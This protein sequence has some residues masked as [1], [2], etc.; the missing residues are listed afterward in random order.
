M[1]QV[2][3]KDYDKEELMRLVGDVSEIAG[4]KKYELLDGKGRGVRAVD[5]WTGT[6]F[7][8]TVV[9]DRGMDI[10]QTSYCGKSLCWRSSI[11]EVH[12]HFF[13]PEEMGWGRSFPGGLLVTCGLTHYGAP[14]EDEGEK[15]GLHGRISHIPA[16]K[17]C[18]DEKWEK[19]D[20]EPS[21][22]GLLRESAIF[23]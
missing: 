11:G 7:S 20:Y 13:E 14:C 4:M 19:D 8:F 21:L 16:E 9:L 17:V 12:P 15:L 10:S 1:A 18:L 23:C 5:I 3:G 6:G 2:F 22:S